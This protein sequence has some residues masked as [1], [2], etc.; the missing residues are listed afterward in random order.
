[1]VEFDDSDKTPILLHP[2]KRA[3]L[4]L[5]GQEL[6]ND[7][8]FFEAHEAW[9]ELWRAEAGR[10]RAFVQGLI[11]VAGHFV[12]VGKGNWSGARS[13]A[14]LARGKFAAA[15]RQ[16]VYRALDIAPLLA[17]LDYNIALLDGHIAHAIEVA[18]PAPGTGSFI[19]PKLLEK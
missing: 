19:T 7:E 5:K 1:M 9:E 4:L 15:A 2:A 12:H 3:E 17:A 18:R 10:D 14:F 11:L 16:P 13:L 8:R 6:F